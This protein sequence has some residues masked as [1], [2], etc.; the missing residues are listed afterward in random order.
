MRKKGLLS[1]VMGMALSLTPGPVLADW[2]QDGGSINNNTVLPADRPAIA[3][4]NG[5]TNTV[6]V[7]WQEHNGTNYEVFAK[8]YDGVGWI[9]LNGPVNNNLT[10]NAVAPD[11][12]MQGQIPM[13]CWSETESANGQV[14]V[15]MYNGGNW[16][17]F[18]TLPNLNNNDAVGP[19]MAID[20]LTP[21]VLVTWQEHTGSLYE[22]FVRK[23]NGLNWDS[24]FRLNVGGGNNA[25]APDITAHN[26]NMFVAFQ[27]KMAGMPMRV[28]V[29]GGSFWGNFGAVNKD[30]NQNAT[31]PRINAEGSVP[32]VVWEEYNGSNREIFVKRHNGLWELQDLGNLTTS[33]SLNRNATQ[34]AFAPDIDIYNGTPYVAWCESNGTNTQVWVKRFIAGGEGWSLLGGPLNVSPGN[35]ANNPDIH[36][37]NGTPYV[38]WAEV[39]AS[40]NCYIYCKHWCWPTPTVTPTLSSS[41]TSTPTPTITPTLS[42]SATY[43]QTPTITPTLSLSVTSTQTP[44]IT[45]GGTTPYT[46]TIT[47]TLAVSTSVPTFTPTSGTVTAYRSFTITPTLRIKLPDRDSPVVIRGNVL[48][49]SV[50]QPMQ[51]GL[52]LERTQRVKIKVYTLRGKLV[53]TLVD[54]VVNAGSFET[55]WNGAN[56]DRLMV[57]S[58]VYIIYIETEQFKEKRKMVVVR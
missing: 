4:T 15:K 18:G 34:D 2:L 43:T 44:T 12:G 11:M 48:K 39:D 1:L 31:N 13:I 28:Y 20:N 35:D 19:R 57:R 46:L 40:S 54:R 58:G 50:Q 30:M 6:Y 33:G 56:Q 3:E 53:T 17:Q 42:C 51:I 10:E 47:P 52:Y 29:R 36:V 14:R 7:T 38:A 27:E 55:A 24:P 25:Y 23:L 5:T 37:I 21:L 41:V 22:V 16:Q 49:P 45:P 9:H 26:D 8:E 32:Y